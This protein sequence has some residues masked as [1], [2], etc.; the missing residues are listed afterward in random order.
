MGYGRAR[1]DIYSSLLYW[2]W[3]IFYFDKET[4]GRNT[5]IE[6]GQF[7]PKINLNLRSCSL[8]GLAF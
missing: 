5:D 4:W 6:I 3:H 8:A 2:R 7:L 1:C